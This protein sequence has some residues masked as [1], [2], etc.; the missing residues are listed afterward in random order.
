MDFPSG[1]VHAIANGLRTPIL[2]GYLVI[3]LRGRKI[4]HPRERLKGRC[5]ISLFAFARALPVNERASTLG[6]AW[7]QTCYCD[8]TRLFFRVTPPSSNPEWTWPRS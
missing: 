2:S 5:T 8:I 1:S 4:M 6:S 3:G 7:S